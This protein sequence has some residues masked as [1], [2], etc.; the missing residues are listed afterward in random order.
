[1]RLTFVMEAGDAGLLERVR[2]I[3]TVVPGKGGFET[4]T[5]TI[6]CAARFVSR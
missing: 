3:E 5:L 4:V 2:S 1:M 6:R